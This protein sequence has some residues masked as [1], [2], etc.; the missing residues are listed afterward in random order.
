MLLRRLM[1]VAIVL[2]LV[3]AVLA[4]WGIERV[5]ARD[6]AVA[7]ERMA[8]TATTDLVRARCEAN[9]NW[10]LAGPREAAP[11]AALL[12]L[13]DGDV[14][15][16]RPDVN[17]RPVEF[18]A[19]DIEYIGQS[20]AAPRMPQTMR[21]RLRAGQTSV[22]E[23]FVTSEGTGVQTAF[24]TTWDGSCAVLLF[25]MHPRPRQWRERAMMFA[26][27]WAGAFVAILLVA[28]PLDW[29]IRRLGAQMRA[30]ARTEYHEAALVGGRDELSSL[31][32]AFNAAALDVRR[33]QTDV[34]DRDAEH[35]RFVAYVGAD[36]DEPLRAVL[37][38]GDTRQIASLALHLGNILT[39]A[40]F[41][42]PPGSC[43]GSSG[44]G[45]GGDDR[46]G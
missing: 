26:A 43:S 14:L 4:S 38:S 17:T 15:A 31:G 24:H 3:C 34:R 44:R 39:G 45:G 18:F 33:L 25:R 21:A 32:F 5:R 35:R 13:P 23:P 8:A 29:R 40:R 20:T 19:Y 41:R 2:G 27:L 22:T 46:R 11:S 16:H 36:V 28:W 37:T 1:A 7:I 10:F 42:D 6:R 30:S 12:A 9:P